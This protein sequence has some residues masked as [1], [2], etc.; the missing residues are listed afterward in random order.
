[1]FNNEIR[2]QA[3]RQAPT[4]LTRTGPGRRLWRDIVGSGRYVLRPDELRILE[5]A[6]HHADRI[7]KLRA[8]TWDGLRFG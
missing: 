3:R 4:K 2:T 8:A 5:D 1:M 6:C 7:E